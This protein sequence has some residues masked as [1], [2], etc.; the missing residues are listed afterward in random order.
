MCAAEKIYC[1]N[2]ATSVADPDPGSGA[3][4]TLGSGT[5]FFWISYP[6]SQIHIFESLMT[7]L[8]V[9]SSVMLCKVFSSPAQ[10]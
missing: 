5:G 6:R 9:K 1:N 7:F 8:G 10:K 2:L 4:L 3:F